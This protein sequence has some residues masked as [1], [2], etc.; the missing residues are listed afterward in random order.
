MAGRD[1][2]RVLEGE[3]QIGEFESLEDALDFLSE[4]T[5][6]EDTR[7]GWEDDFGW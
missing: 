3:R 4:K 2:F 6:E 7:D 5:G 1:P